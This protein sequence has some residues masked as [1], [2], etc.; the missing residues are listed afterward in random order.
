MGH[1]AEPDPSKPTGSVR[2]RIEGKG[3]TVMRRPPCTSWDGE[4]CT[5]ELFDGA[6]SVADCEGCDSY[7]G[8]PRGLG[9]RVER[10]L[11]ATGVHQV[12]KKATGGGCGCSKRRTKLNRISGGLADG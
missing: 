11:K 10:V 9:D 4:R 1:I 2:M 6:P 12:V 3:G 5:L 8:A 7:T